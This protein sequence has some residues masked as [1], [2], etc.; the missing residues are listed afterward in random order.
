[1]PD[2]PVKNLVVCCDGTANEFA[3][4]RTNVVKLFFTLVHDPIRQVV[5]YHPGVGTMEPPGSL[6]RLSRGI[7]KLLGRAIGFGLEA[8]I[9]DTYA[10]LMNHFNEGDQAYFFGFSRGAYTVRAVTALLH[11]YGLLRPAMNP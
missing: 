10:F 7:T 8:D 6:T 11:M 1:M 9:R 3:R 2:N 5:F 4:D